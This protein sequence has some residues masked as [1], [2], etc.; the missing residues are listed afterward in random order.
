LLNVGTVRNLHSEMSEK[1]TAHTSFIVAKAKAVPLHATGRFGGDECSSY[2]LSTSVLDGGE[3]S[4][5]RPGRALAPG[6]GAL[7]SIVLVQEAGWA[8]EPV[9]TQKLEK[10]I[11]SLLPGVEPRSPGRPARSQTL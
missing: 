10:K 5:S 8:A 9:W 11:I 2:S 6:K 4:A 7:V 1:T 3:C